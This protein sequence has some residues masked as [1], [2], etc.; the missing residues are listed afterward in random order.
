VTCGKNV[1]TPLHFT[2]IQNIPPRSYHFMEP[3]KQK[4]GMSRDFVLSGIYRHDLFLLLAI[5][6]PV[7]AA[8]FTCMTSACDHEC[9]GRLGSEPVFN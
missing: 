6:H 7:S 8:S 4:T 5:A 1:K 3:A 2:T 9:L